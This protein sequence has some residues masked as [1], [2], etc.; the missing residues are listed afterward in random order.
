MTD[1]SVK[2]KVAKPKVEIEIEGES[3]ALDTIPSE[4]SG[5]V[6]AEREKLL[7]VID[8]RALVSDLGRVGGF[9]RIA[10]NGVGAA[11]YEYTKEQIEIQ[12]L[13]YDI[14][15]LCDKS[16]LTVAKFKKASS[17]IVT[18]LQCTYG[19]LLDNLEEMALETLSAISKLAGEMEKAALELHDEFIAEEEKVIA[20]L[21]NTQQAK[22]IQ[23]SKV[24]EERKRRIQLEEDYK[25]E[26]VLMKEHRE[27]ESE[28]EARRRDLEE[29]EDEAISQ[30]GAVNVRT[31]LKRLGNSLTANFG[32]KLFDT[33][34][35][36]PEKKAKILRQNR[37]D[38]LEAEKAIREKRQQALAN[39]S[40]FTA[41]L[42]QCSNDHEMAECAVEALHEAVGALKHLSAVMMQAA[43][44][45]KQMQDHCHSLAESEMKSQVEKVLTF[46][47]ERR[48]KVW[49]SSAFKRK[50]IE[51]YSGWVA[52][53]SVCTI[54][55]EHIKK[56]QKD[57]YSYITEN[58]TYEESKK[59]L[60]SLAEDFMADLKRDQK[61]LAE[62]D[63]KA[64]QEIL[65]LGPAKGN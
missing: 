63:L 15:R 40:S 49:T 59:I 17:S 32:V 31:T 45:W 4:N 22:Q 48:L 26:Q 38:A 55:I 3:Y 14:T 30:I 53:N 57:L 64:Q 61:A 33:E 13:G 39:M 37:L 41:K 29:Q 27:K 2:P 20:A 54:Y 44:F 25:R 60:P 21:E 65:A 18:D 47:E 36:S 34:E 7:G 16:A 43:L 5:V 62:K 11:G 9:I 46:P 10:Y 51:F 35:D 56:T 50:A 23:A 12:R 42:K 6:K 58:P 52:L 28:A 1:R 19:Y 8:L 24:T